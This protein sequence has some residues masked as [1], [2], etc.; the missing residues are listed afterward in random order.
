VRRKLARG[1]A[2]LQK[3]LQSLDAAG[4]MVRNKQERAVVNA[5]V[6]AGAVLVAG[7]IS[8]TVLYSEV[9]HTRALPG[10][11]NFL[12]AT[13]GDGLVLPVMT[14]LLVFASG[15]LPRAPRDVLAGT[16]AALIGASLGIATQ[17]EWLRDPSPRLNWTLPQPHHFNLAGVY[18]AVF[19]TAL[20]AVAAGLW[21]LVLLR[22]AWAPGRLAVCRDAVA[23]SVLAALAG[24]VFV[25]LL[26][27]DSLPD[28]SQAG[29]ATV[30]VAGGGVGLVLVVTALM[31]AAR[32]SRGQR[33]RRLAAS[34]NAADEAGVSA[35]AITAV[36]ER[37]AVVLRCGAVAT[38]CIAGPAGPPH[39]ISLRLLTAVLVALACWA[40]L[41]TTVVR[42]RGL[43]SVLA[44][45]D[46]VVVTAVVLLQR[47]LV[48]PALI[49]DNTSWTLVLASSA[50]FISQLILRRSWTGP[51]IAVGVAVAY[52]LTQ[53]ERTAGPV[54]LLL[55]AAVTRTLM[56][57]LRRGG[58]SADIAVA[59][60][61]RVEREEQ[62]RSQRRADELEQYRRLHDTILATLTVAASGAVGHSSVTLREQAA[63]DLGV[64]AS[65]RGLPFSTGGDVSTE[66]VD[67]AGPLAES[68]LASDVRAR[69][70]GSAK[71]P[72]V[73]AEA[74]TR[75]VS[76]ALANVARYAGTGE[77][78]VLLE[79][80]DGQ[81]VV[82]I[83]DQGYGFDAAAV[84]A[85]KRGIRE[86]I[87]G[88]MES[89]GGAAEVTS[90]LGQGTLVRL[91]W[92]GM[93]AFLPAEPP[94]TLSDSA[95][96]IFNARYIRGL[97]IATVIVVAGW[98]VAGAGLSLLSHF[99][100][101]TSP[102]IEVAA[103]TVQAGVIGVAAVLLLRGRLGRRV[104]W[105][106]VGLDTVA[107]IAAVAACPTD[108]MLS[109]NWA[110]GA[111]VWVGVL[112]LLHRPLWELVTLMAVAALITFC[113]LAVVSDLHRGPVSG[114]I[115][116]LYASASIQ[117]AVVIAARA[118][119]GAAKQAAEATH[120]AART[121][122]RRSIAE[123]VHADR[124]S[125]YRAVRE[126]NEPLL[127]G[128]ADGSL[129][130][131]DPEV[132]HA[133]A[134]QAAR[135]RRMFAEGDDV[136][137]RLLHELHACADIADRRGVAVDW[138]TAG[139]VPPIPETARRQLTEAAIA[140]LA[141]AQ[142]RARITVISDQAGV[143]VGLFCDSAADAPPTPLD[144]EIA[145]TSQRDH[146]GLWME[147]QWPAR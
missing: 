15:R 6:A 133:C 58:R 122:T 35:R 51:A 10:L 14:G 96:V 11:F 33:L 129:H 26:V 82:T 71:A 141:S 34:R 102:A 111:T 44:V 131:D 109:A 54:I 53:P 23:A 132:Q 110:W 139:A 2:N 20:C 3:D 55:Q 9:P 124:Q 137:N 147:A 43:P 92:P 75:S 47:R 140:V 100:L 38:A 68:A 29:T 63:S 45:A 146:D 12:S 50:V 135:L 80:R 119:G 95:A 89:V 106:L 66:V 143:A 73:V 130:G 127:Q 121:A 30:T 136:P 87:I 69:F 56:W 79:C 97:E 32:I 46:S 40:V 4:R 144:G 113:A 36:T 142:A 103:W 76:A 37:Y 42:R 134:V 59:D 48:S 83:R 17:V 123:A 128:L 7:F 117:L 84:P 27:A 5:V 126:N 24:V 85:S 19:L 57:Q 101:Y 13:W 86:S 145:V 39:R 41:F 64:L 114:Y 81:I 98:Q 115:S 52:G 90:R 104:A 77:A 16:G 108:G 88:R 112:V 72:Q 105:G 1:S 138:A 28:R 67:L 99:S 78:E 116:T 61:A 49:A 31:T 93:S 120:T 65:L 125:R 21:T 94:V 74:I 60:S 18:H 25:V 118:L 22:L 70:A 91:W 62:V 107:G 8:L